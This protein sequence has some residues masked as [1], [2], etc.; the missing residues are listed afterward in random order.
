MSNDLFANAFTIS[1]SPHTS[2]TEA[3][4]NISGFTAEAGEPNTAGST[5]GNSAWWKVTPA[6]NGFI[7]LDTDLTTALGSGTDTVMGIYT[8]SAVNALTMVAEN[9]DG[10][11]GTTSELNNIPVTAGITYHIKVDSFGGS[12]PMNVVLRHSLTAITT[13]VSDTFTAGDGTPITSHMPDVGG[14]WLVGAQNDFVGSTPTIQSNA[15]EAAGD[16]KG[17]FSSTVAGSADYNLQASTNVGAASGFHQIQ[18]CA[19]CTNIA[20]STQKFEGYACQFGYDNGTGWRVLIWKQDH[21]GNNTT[22]G[23]Y[24]PTITPSTVHTLRFELS[25]TSLI[26]KLDGTQVLSVTDTTYAA[27]GNFGWVAW[28]QSLDTFTTDGVAAPSPTAFWTGFVETT[29]VDA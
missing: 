7:S 28:G 14:A 26:A 19:R 23:T 27:A 5:A 12:S 9:D 10:A 2:V 13:L 29:E 1:G 24:V 25:G 18:L 6:S 8:G 4:V 11:V 20:S 15:I 21:L 17:I 3:P 22:L 16:Y